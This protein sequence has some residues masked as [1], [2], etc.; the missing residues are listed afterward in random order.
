MAMPFKRRIL[1]AAIMVLAI[2][3]CSAN[4]AVTPNAVTASSR[5]P[6]QNSAGPAPA[7]TTSILKLLT[8]DVTIGSTI[9][10]ANGDKGPRAATVVQYDEGAL[11]KGQVLVCNFEDSSGNA[12]NGTTIERLDPLAKATTFFQS[13]AIEG[14]DGDAV[15]GGDQ[16]YAT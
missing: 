2:C 16:V 5:G 12:G 14:C 7:D 6:N 1:L 8:K 11:K 10:P 9:D 13:T 4:G 15:T 3:A